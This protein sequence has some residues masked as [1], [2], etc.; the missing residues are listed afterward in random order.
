MILIA[1]YK[2]L[3]LFKN[4]YFKFK[5]K[6]FF[7]NCQISNFKKKITVFKFLKTAIFF[8]YLRDSDF[9]FII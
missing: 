5:R 1:V 2:N 9:I 8:D 6:K 3:I 4:N 7:Q